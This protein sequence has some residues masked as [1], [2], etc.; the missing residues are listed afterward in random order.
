LLSQRSAGRHPAILHGLAGYR[1]CACLS[2]NRRDS[3][4]IASKNRT[5]GKIRQRVFASSTILGLLFPKLDI[6]HSS[7]LMKL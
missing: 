3:A 4:A 1:A 7:H 2:K 6:F 5:A